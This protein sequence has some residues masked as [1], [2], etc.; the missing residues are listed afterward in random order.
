[1]FAHKRGEFWVWE[2]WPLAV[3]H[4]LTQHKLSKNKKKLT[5]EEDLFEIEFRRVRNQA[6]H[7]LAQLDKSSA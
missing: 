2:T 5:V 7:F 4:Y 3:N 1:M 6:E